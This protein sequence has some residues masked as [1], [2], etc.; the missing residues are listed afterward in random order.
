MSTRETLLRNIK[1]EEVTIPDL[2]AVFKGWVNSEVS[3]YY[4]K[5][6]PVSNTRL[7]RYLRTSSTTHSESS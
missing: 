7:E 3:P 2:F 1:G 4:K 5:L 6:I